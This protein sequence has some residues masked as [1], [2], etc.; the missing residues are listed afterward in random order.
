MVYECESAEN[1]LTED[2]VYVL[3]NGVAVPE[4]VPDDREVNGIAA[5]D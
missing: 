4:T 1:M 5:D 2:T 3:K